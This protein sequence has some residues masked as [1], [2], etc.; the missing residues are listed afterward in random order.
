MISA[1]VVLN[2]EFWL[3]WLFD[4]LQPK[5]TEELGE[6]FRAWLYLTGCAVPSVVKRAVLNLL[7]GALFPVFR[8]GWLFD[9]LQ[10]KLTEELLMHFI[11]RL[12]LLLR[13]SL[14]CGWAGCLTSC[15]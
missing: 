3:V 10:L 11:A 2:P 9:E 13:C 14:S 8:L 12:L 4:E 7:L 15:S 1:L 6:C 5:L